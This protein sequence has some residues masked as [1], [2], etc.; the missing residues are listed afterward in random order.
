MK[1][2]KTVLL[3]FLVAGL[4]AY[5]RF[6]ERGRMSSEQ[7]RE[8]MRQAFDLPVERITRIGVRGPEL[9]LSLFTTP[10]GWRLE[11]PKGARASEA[12]V[13]QTLAR[14]RSLD[15]GELITPADMKER[16]QTLADFG[17][18]VPGLV[19]KLETPRER[20][21]YRIGDPNPLGNALYVKE[22]STQ[23]IMLVSSDL[24]KIIPADP[25]AFRDRDLVPLQVSDLHSLTLVQSDRVL[26]LARDNDR[27][28]F[29]EPVNA[30]ADPERMDQLLQKLSTARIEGM[31]DDPAA[32]G[33]YGF[34]EDSD[35]I[36]LR[37]AGSGVPYEITLGGD[38]PENPDACYAR[39]S[40]Q[41][42]LVLV[43]KGLRRMARTEM[44]ALR[45]RD[46]L[47][48]T[49][50]DLRAVV[51]AHPDRTL[52]VEREGME[53][54]LVSPVSHAASPDRIQQMLQTW[55]DARIA[56]FPE[57]DSAPGTQYRVT[58]APTE[59][60]GLPVF[61]FEVLVGDPGPGR[62][63][64][65]RAEG[66]EVLLVVPDLVRFSPVEVLPYLS[67]RMLAFDAANAVRVSVRR[68]GEAR[69][70]LRDEPGGEWRAA[71]E[72]RRVE[73]GALTELLGELSD[74]RAERLV[75]LNPASLEPYGLHEPD[76]RVS[77]GLGG[78]QP[79]NR[80]LLVSRGG[81]YDSPMGMVQGE[82]VVFRLSGEQWDT[83]RAPIVA[84]ET[85][86]PGTGDGEE[87]DTP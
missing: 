70:A 84:T 76:L 77:I 64:I 11:H 73:T 22:E 29:T 60:S 87:A 53:W 86:R 68:A 61:G 67:R 16:G 25:Q 71:G 48:L 44:A 2:T 13:R 66:E 79:T 47:T 62:V 45:D 46:L 49:Y 82:E 65:R 4:G 18:A 57:M 33:D 42:G 75:E 63:W 39:L 28:M 80:T 43:S 37:A 50:D 52:R 21:E 69:E 81:E 17:L 83:L 55:R 6:H 19:L 7:R 36:R 56:D 32:D 1:A 72:G 74:L 35:V 41:E 78:D 14:I 59:A 27:W 58:F 40:G 3:L 12:M 30:P 31:V 15:R 38:A 34:D 54:R 23:N 8:R 20:R 26:R 85:V 24:M 10:K 51:V 9:D 5:I